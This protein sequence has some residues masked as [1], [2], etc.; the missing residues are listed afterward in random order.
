MSLLAVFVLATL[1]Q[2][3]VS[4]GKFTLAGRTLEAAV[5]SWKGV[6]EVNTLTEDGRTYQF[7]AGQ[8][9]ASTGDWDEARRLGSMPASGTT[10]DWPTD[11]YAFSRSDVLS[12]N[13]FWIQRQGEL[14]EKDWPA[15]QQETALFCGLVSA[16]TH[17][18][19]RIV[20][21]WNLEPE[22]QY[23]G[24]EGYSPSFLESY[25]R[26]RLN[27]GVASVIALTSAQMSGNQFAV[28][29]QTPIST[30]DAYASFDRARPGQLARAMFNAWARTL[31]TRMRQ[32]GWKVSDSAF[33]VSTPAESWGA[34]LPLADVESGVPTAA[35][36]E[37]AKPKMAAFASHLPEPW[38]FA[39]RSWREVRDDPFAKLPTL[40]DARLAELL[41]GKELKSEKSGA[42]VRIQVDGTGVG[43]NAGQAAML[44][45]RDSHQLLAVKLPFVDLVDHRI[46]GLKATGIWFDAK[47]S[48]VVFA[49]SGLSE[50][51]S[52]AELLKVPQTSTPSGNEPINL[53]FDPGQAEALP[54]S[55]GFAAKTVADN[56]RGSVGEIR[57]LSPQRAGWIQLVGAFDAAKN[58]FLEFYVRPRASTWPV[59]LRVVGEGWAGGCYR[60]FGR[61]RP[62]G[63]ITVA[64]SD[65]G[66]IDLDVKTEPT[67]QHVVIDLRLLQP[68][69]SLPVKGIYLSVPPYGAADY[70]NGDAPALLIDDLGLL[71]AS[72]GPLTPT[73]TDPAEWA[74]NETSKVPEERALFAAQS[75]ATDSLIKLLKDPDS[76]VRLNAA[77]RFQALK[78]PGSVPNLAEMSR[79]AN[80]RVAQAASK[81]LAFQGGDAASDALRYTL[82]FG[83]GDQVKRFA[84]DN[85]PAKDD[86]KLLGEFSVA[87]VL[88]SAYT[89]KAAVEAIARLPIKETPMVLMAFLNDLDPMVRLAVVER[90]GMNETVQKR[91]AYIVE[92][93]PADVVRAAAA[94]RLLAISDPVA[95]QLVKDPS[96]L[97]KTSALQTVAEGGTAKEFVVQLTRDSDP[98]VRA[99]AY[100]VLSRFS[101][102]PDLSAGFAETDSRVLRAVLS[103]ATIKKIAVS[104]DVKRRA[105]ESRDEDLVR[106]AANLPS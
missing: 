90:S 23:L 13:G 33:N 95:M 24:I 78:S 102:D 31:P 27:D 85:I 11:I 43:V 32:A 61:T 93:D 70:P 35:W 41:G 9:T 97:A 55:G 56:T 36:P 37:M 51:T 73:S 92:S 26:P 59:E 67:W 81:A 64:W 3:P 46:G 99:A 48:W 77:I 6:F 98:V 74:A 89:R 69:G 34:P 87:L 53:N 12:A 63:G 94:L 44:L 14:L 82:Q 65:E 25:F 39:A 100:D 20:P 4:L 47:A 16:Y 103:L 54:T 106:V 7:T 62:I 71:T 2:A 10:V 8:L 84:L 60:M 101:G 105:L 68:G 66:A 75:S 40:S 50:T 38:P 49:T 76:V 80:P 72:T 1:P 52:D 86:R 5:P 42:S 96:P 30:V 58:P 91:F 17:N 21:K 19:V 15:M 83:L 79:N 104:P 18:R 45:H 28:V 22:L 88:R 29:N 57:E